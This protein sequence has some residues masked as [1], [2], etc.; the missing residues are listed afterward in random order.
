MG[1]RWPSLFKVRGCLADASL[2]LLVLPPLAISGSPAYS[3]FAY[4][5]MAP[6]IGVAAFLAVHNL[7]LVGVRPTLTGLAMVGGMAW[8]LADAS[9]SLAGPIAA[10]ALGAGVGLSYSESLRKGLL[11]SALPF[12]VLLVALRLL[13]SRDAAIATGMIEMSV[14]TF[15]SLLC[16]IHRSQS[17]RTRVTPSPITRERNLS[18]SIGRREFLEA[19][20]GSS[21]L[22]SFAYLGATTPEA[23]WFG[24]MITHA[25][26]GQNL[27][28]LTFDDGPNV[29]YTLK[30]KDILDSYRVKGTFFTVGKALAARPDISRALM[31]GGHLLADH[32]YNHDYYRWLDPRYPELQKTQDEFLRQ[33]GVRPAF[34]RPPHG[35]RSPFVTRVVSNRKIKMVGWDV[36]ADDWA[37]TDGEL[38][39]HRILAGAQ[40]G[41]IILL[42]DGLDGDLTADRSVL[43]AALPLILEGLKSRG[44]RPVGLDELLQTPGYLV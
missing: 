29:E 42:H 1:V 20:L 44:L 34:Y 8:A 28:S 32:S 21:A 14:A 23:G 11:I 18:L 35:T 16:L 6:M 27:V 15:A 2:G 41:S 36:S 3:T 4:E 26:R 19:A 40:A 38:V 22:V 37:A 12:A 5:A 9:Y 33:L 31:D 13:G 17:G 24:S 10:A 43:L 7:R 39:A 25:S 30:V